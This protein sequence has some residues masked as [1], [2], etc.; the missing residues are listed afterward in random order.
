MSTATEQLIKVQD[1]ILE[2]LA[3]IQKPVVEA[4]KKLADRAEAVVPEVPAVPGSDKL[5]TVNELIA[6]RLVRKR[7]HAVTVARTGREAVT[8]M[9]AQS[10]DLVLMD[11]QMPEMDGLQATAELRQH[12]RASSK[13]M[14]VVAMTA[15]AMVGDRERFVAAG[16]DGYLSKPDSPEALF[17]EIQRVMGAAIA[18]RPADTAPADT[19]PALTAPPARFALA[20]AGIENDVELFA[21]LGPLAIREMESAAHLVCQLAQDGAFGKLMTEAHRLK[22]SWPL[23]AESPAEG[24]L[25]GQLESA[26]RQCDAVQ[27]LAIA[28]RL[29]IAQTEAARAL[30]QW[31]DQHAHT[32]PKETSA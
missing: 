4:V 8:M 22:S 24:A 28:E 12:E 15:H 19:A 1:Q 2:T 13:H 18:N 9:L 16:M 27:A 5:P 23:Y 21:E 20:L 17:A 11:V 31:L 32:I 26:A 10:F 30:R 7:G 14:Q 3:S 25:A 29:A 6:T